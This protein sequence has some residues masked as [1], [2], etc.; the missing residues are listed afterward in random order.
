MVHGDRQGSVPIHLSHLAEKI[1]P[2]IRSTLQDIELPLM[3]HFMR[4]RAHDFLL[5][6]LG[7][8]ND[9]SE[10]GKGEANF[11]HSRR[12]TTIPIQSRTRSSSTHEHADR[13]SQPPTPCY[14]NRREAAIEEPGVE[15]NPDI[16]KVLSCKNRQQ[17]I[18]QEL[19]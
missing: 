1:R 19:L 13:G 8:L 14:V 15:F 5:A 18:A 11:S 6:I 7:P 4:Q 17:Q 10:E 16:L 12:A 3:N 9:L 2:M